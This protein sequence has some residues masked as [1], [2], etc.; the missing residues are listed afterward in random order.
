MYEEIFI[1][2]ALVKKKLPKLN[3]TKKNHSILIFAFRLDNIRI[4]QKLYYALGI[5]S[6]EQS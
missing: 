4:Q 1:F 2:L 5:V 3:L 6:R